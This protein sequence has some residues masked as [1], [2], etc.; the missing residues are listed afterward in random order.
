[1]IPDLTFRSSAGAPTATI[2]LNAQNFPGGAFFGDQPSAVSRGI[3]VPV[4]QFTEQNFIRLRGRA[5]AFRIES[6]Q[7]GTHWRL[8]SPRLDIRTDGRR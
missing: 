8:G 5:V 1:M 7:V 2:T 6:N 3:S 4:N